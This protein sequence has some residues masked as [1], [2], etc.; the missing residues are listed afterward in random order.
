MQLLATC[1]LFEG[2]SESQLQRLGAVTTEA[3]MQK[4]KWL[5]FEGEEAKELYVLKQGAVELMT[6]VDDDFELPIAMLRD[7]GSCFGT[8]SLIAPH[9]CSLSSRCAE[10]GSLLVIK[11]ADLQKLILE[12]R[13][14]GC[15]IMTNWAGHLLNRLK[16]TRQELKIH[17]KTL[18]KSMHP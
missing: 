12:D 9:E 15:T 17:F 16:E 3:R 1:Y 10:Q 5:F 11:Q 18:F 2:L 6:K 13:E 4:G 7:P 14:L 8:S